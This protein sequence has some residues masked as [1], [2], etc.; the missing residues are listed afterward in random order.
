MVKLNLNWNQIYDEYKAGKT[1]EELSKKYNCFYQTI[2]K[3]FKI[4]G[5]KKR[6]KSEALKLSIIKNPKFGENTNNWK[7]GRIIR[8]GRVFLRID[9]KYKL[10]SHL[11][12]CNFHKIDKIPIGFE[13][14]HI[15]RNPENNS[16]DNLQLL[17]E[18]EHKSL[19]GKSNSYSMHEGIR[20][21]ETLISSSELSGKTS[22]KR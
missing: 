7:G 9:G 18:Y 13:L 6:T 4:L 11:V 22:D 2:N 17:T 16:I 5:F 21:P 15:D 1:I 10:E 3:N 19:K 20:T 12:Y 8:K 14:H